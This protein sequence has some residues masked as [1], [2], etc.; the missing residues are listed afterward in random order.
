VS[1]QDNGLACRLGQG[2]GAAPPGREREELPH[3]L[4]G[5]GRAAARLADR[6][7]R[8]RTRPSGHGLAGRHQVTT[9]PGPWSLPGIRARRDHLPRW[10]SPVASRRS[11]GLRHVVP[12]ALTRGLP[13]IPRRSARRWYHLRS[14]VGI[15]ST[16]T[17]PGC[18]SARRAV[19]RAMTCGFL[20]IRLGQTRGITSQRPTLRHAP[21]NTETK[22]LAPL[23]CSD[24]P[25]QASDLEP[26]YGI[27]P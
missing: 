8:M 18:A 20:G 24:L 3:L 6:P 16:E 11:P 10:C 17:T 13:S 1:A 2:P 9:A 12:A 22:S 19:V 23:A 14:R 27:E 26:P 21:A 5:P 15:R 25:D 7:G 4:V